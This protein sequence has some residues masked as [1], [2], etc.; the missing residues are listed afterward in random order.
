[1]PPV[2]VVVIVSALF[3]LVLSVTSLLGGAR[4]EQRSTGYIVR[5]HGRVWQPNGSV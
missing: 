2:M 4:L 1:M 5:Y 3:E